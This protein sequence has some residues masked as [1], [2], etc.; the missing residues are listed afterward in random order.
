MGTGKIVELPIAYCT[1]LTFF[2]VFSLLSFYPFLS[3]QAA[4]NVDLKEHL[5][6]V[7]V[8]GDIGTGKTSIIKVCPPPSNPP[9][10]PAATAWFIR[11]R[12][13]N[14]CI[15]SNFARI[16]TRVGWAGGRSTQQF[17]RRKFRGCG[18]AVEFRVCCGGLAQP[19]PCVCVIVIPAV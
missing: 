7:L 16:H 17:T 6:K 15:V 18:G 14:S 11:Q 10:R 9:S 5:F 12:T 13:K 8:V 3:W 19:Y 1:T 4:A 2:H